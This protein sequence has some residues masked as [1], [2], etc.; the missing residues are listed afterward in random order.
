MTGL[1]GIQ[2][3]EI[4]Y[5]WHLKNDWAVQASAEVPFLRKLLC[6]KGLEKGHFK[7]K[8]QVQYPFGIKAL[9]SPGMIQDLAQLFQRENTE[10]LKSVLFYL[11]WNAGIIFDLVY[12]V[13]LLV[14]SLILSGDLC[15]ARKFMQR[16]SAQQYCGN[17]PVI[18]EQTREARI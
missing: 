11:N 2:Q 13:Y 6:C 9:I 8:F 1:S 18:R 14:R 5:R 10:P 17:R 16:Q 4:E 7:P 3:L 12:N 15:S